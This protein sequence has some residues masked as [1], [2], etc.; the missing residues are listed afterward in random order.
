MVGSCGADVS[1]VASWMGW[2]RTLASVLVVSLDGI[3]SSVGAMGS[4]G[5]RRSEMEWKAS[6]VWSQGARDSP[7]QMHVCKALLAFYQFPLAL[8][9]VFANLPPFHKSISQ[10]EGHFEAQRWFRSQRGVSQPKG[11]EKKEKKF[12]QPFRSCKTPCEM[13]L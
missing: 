7:L 5:L 6:C 12:S 3:V 13:G 10:F 8:Q 11:D 1:V 4:D 2:I 9:G